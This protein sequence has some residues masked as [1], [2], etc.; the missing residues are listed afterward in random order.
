MPG[1]MHQ[2]SCG[3]KQAAIKKEPDK[4]IKNMAEGEPIPS[5][6]SWRA[7]PTMTAIII[8]AYPV[9]NICAHRSW[10][11]RTRKKNCK[12]SQSDK[13]GLYMNE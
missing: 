1:T 11:T 6:P 10:K 8:I 4:A 7:V 2:N 3:C 9:D 12:Y 13:A 5:S